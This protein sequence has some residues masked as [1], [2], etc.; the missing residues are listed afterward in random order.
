MAPGQT[1]GQPMVTVSI[2]V[3]GGGPGKNWRI[4]C[5]Q[6]FRGFLEKAGLTGHMPRVFPCGSRDDT[7]KDFRVA[8]REVESGEIPLLLVDSEGPV[9]PNRKTWQHLRSRDGWERPNIASDDQA[10][11]MVQCMESWFLADV[12]ALRDFFGAGFK[13]SSLPKRNDIENVRK[14]DVLKQLES[15]S[16][17][18]RKG[19]YHKG[20]H[21]FDILGQIDPAQVTERSCHARQLVDTLRA[22]F[23]PT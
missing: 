14:D 16:R 13:E 6:G 18:S 9:T 22:H 15:A 11:L 1:W 3:E 12:P 4:K 5:R 7:L 21:S 20:R 8:L 10:H 2:Y 17:N 23:I 19:T